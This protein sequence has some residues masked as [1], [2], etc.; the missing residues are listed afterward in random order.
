MSKRPAERQVFPVVVVHAVTAAGLDDH[1]RLNHQRVW[2][3]I[4][5][6]Q[7]RYER[8]TLYPHVG[9]TQGAARYEAQ[10]PSMVRTGELFSLIYEEIVDDL[11]NELSYRGVPTQPVFPFAYDWRQDNFRSAEQLRQFCDEVIERTNTLFHDARKLEDGAP[12]CDGV[13]IVAHSMGGLVTAACIA[14]NEAWS[15]KRVRRV[16]SLGTPYRGANAA[17][18]KLATGRGPLFGKGRERER[19]MARVTPS[20][21]QLLPEFAGALEGKPKGDIWKPETY[22]PSIAS[23]IGDF[24]SETHADESVRR[25][26]RKS[27][28]IGNELFESM[29]K[30]AKQFRG[31]VDKASPSMLRR[32]GGWL[33][34]VGAGEKTLI[35]TGF[36]TRAQSGTNEVRFRFNEHL[37]YSENSGRLEGDMLTGDGTVPLSAAIPP[38]DS[39][40]KNTVVVTRQDFAFGEWSDRIVA[41]GADFHGALPLLNVAQRW[42]INFFRPEW[43]D[44]ETPRAHRLGQHGNLWGRLAPVPG[45]PTLPSA[46]RQ[47]REALRDLWLP[48]GF[49]TLQLSDCPED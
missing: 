7:H 49:P 35:R 43:L 44:P 37:D 13:D 46:K 26:T 21:Y 16:V 30:L 11:R 14:G 39:P 27:R 15:K 41:K 4:S 12:L 45:A 8:V 10:N 6:A 1:Y 17:L 19:R 29:L 40:W 36:L 48:M 22:Q 24:V 5:M 38:W 9:L 3:P 28:Q 42:I 2:S 18:L 23:A 33:A 31:V 47:R 25:S 20:V 34:I 32:D